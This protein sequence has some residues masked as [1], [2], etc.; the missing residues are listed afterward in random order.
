VSSSS[1]VQPS[2]ALVVPSLT[3]RVDALLTSV[4]RQ[5]LPPA[6]VE[7][8]VGTS[9]SGR[10]RNL[11]V[12]K[13]SAPVLVFA[14]DDAVLGTDDTLAKLVAPLAD[15]GVGVVGTGK[16]IPPESRWFQRLV[17]R[18]VPRIE[19]PVVDRLTDSNPPLDRHGY[20]DVTTTCCAIR[21]EVFQLLGGF[22]EDLV[23]GVDSEFWYRLRAAGYRLV[24]ASHAWVYHP[25]PATL[26]QLLKKH[27]LY[28]IGYAQGVRR[29][30]QLAGGRYFVTPVHA[31]AYALART[32]L[33]APHALLPYSA[34][35][36]SWRPGFKPLRAL[37]SYAAGLGYIYG[38]YRHP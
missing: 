11:G 35:D 26:A 38:W 3:G 31:A 12:A 6:E 22:D 37:S 29:H 28:G 20:T 1:G 10:A 23:R 32:A 18:Q 21:R 30:P 36:T 27:F 34:A 5:T 24:L 17:A 8:V 16:L 7:V 14:D 25:A 15:P 4:A 13:T 19:H 2:V 9:P 33:L